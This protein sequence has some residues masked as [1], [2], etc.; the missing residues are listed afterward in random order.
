MNG[1]DSSISQGTADTSHSL[2]PSVQ[3]WCTEESA[4]NSLCLRLLHRQDDVS[5]VSMFEVSG[6]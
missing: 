3:L 5:E 6:L 1:M 2:C 4:F